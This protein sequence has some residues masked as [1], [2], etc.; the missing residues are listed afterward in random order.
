MYGEMTAEQIDQLLARHRFGRLGFELDGAVYI[1]PI[2]YA[3]EAGVLYGHAAEGT[4]VH[5]MRQNPNVAFEVDEIDDPAHWRSA[6]LHGRYLELH[7]R[8]E[9]REAFERIV[10]Q[11]GGGERS[12]ATW[13]FS[14]D[15]MVVF[16]IDVTARSGRFEERQAYGLRPQRIGPL[17]PAS[18]TA[19]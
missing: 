4:K 17:P 15:H 11:N 2:N 18:G 19:L 3:Y 5:A 13:G 8:A 12:E 10:A 7:N 14:L 9:K 1:I 6:L 16:R